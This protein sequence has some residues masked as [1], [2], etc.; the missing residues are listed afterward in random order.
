MANDPDAPDIAA[1]DKGPMRPTDPD[2][3]VDAAIKWLTDHWGKVNCPI[4]D[5][6][7]LTVRDPV[8]LQPLLKGP[9]PGAVY[10]VIPVICKSCG[11]VQFLDPFISGLLPPTHENEQKALREAEEES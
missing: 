6:E 4:C 3:V 8:A 11:N 5:A 10:P 1:P 2:A 9:F 7:E